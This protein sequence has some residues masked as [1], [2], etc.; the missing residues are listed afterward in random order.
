ML[1]FGVFF[2]EDPVC[3]HGVLGRF[4][5]FVE[6]G[7]EGFQKFLDVSVLIRLVEDPE[8]VPAEGREP[9]VGKDAEM[10]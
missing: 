9:R 8:A 2:L 5:N 10:P 7:G 4:G 3:L 1:G 6:I